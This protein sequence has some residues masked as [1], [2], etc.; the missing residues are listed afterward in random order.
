[1]N[2]GVSIDDIKQAAVLAEISGKSFSEV[3]GMKVSWM[4]VAE[5]L[6][7]THEQIVEM[8]NQVDAHTFTV[9]NLLDKL[10]EVATKNQ[11]EE[12]EA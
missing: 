9:T 1:M 5:K 12:D 11:E 4:Q 2:D 7:V 6:G 10:L 8:A 3:L